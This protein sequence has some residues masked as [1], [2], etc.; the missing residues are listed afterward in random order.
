M[1]GKLFT[2][3]PAPSQCLHHW[4]TWLLVS[5]QPLTAAS[6]LGKGEV[7]LSS[8]LLTMKHWQ[9][10]SC[11]GYCS[12]GELMSVTVT[13]CPGCL[14][15]AHI[16]IP[17]LLHSFL[18]VVIFHSSLKDLWCYPRM[19]KDRTRRCDY[20]VEKKEAGVFSNDEGPRRNRFPWANMTIL[21]E[22][23]WLHTLLDFS[24]ISES[25]TQSSVPSC[26]LSE[27]R[28]AVRTSSWIPP[29]LVLLPWLIVL[30]S[31]LV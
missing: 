11:A 24:L 17:Q 5:Q 25:L 26:D 19:F 6:F 7:S 30:Y 31:W 15:G 12:H 9:V 8:P 18:L 14:F 2:G 3:T 21:R 1:V 28:L 13:S 23:S 22:T 4:R 29:H 10:Q 20:L 16:P 27:Q